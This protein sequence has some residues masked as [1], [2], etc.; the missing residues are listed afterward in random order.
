[1]SSASDGQPAVVGD[2]EDPLAFSSLRL[3]PSEQ[4]PAPE[5]LVAQAL[6][7]MPEDPLDNR[8]AAFTD[9][10]LEVMYDAIR[11]ASLLDFDL[12]AEMQAELNR[13]RG[14]R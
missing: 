14:D 11:D 10:E 2:G 8:L 12:A 3:I 7:A 5:E 6:E 13:R 9:A 1:M 4:V